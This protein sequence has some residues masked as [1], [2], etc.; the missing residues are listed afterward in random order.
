M[1][2]KQLIRSFSRKIRAAR[3]RLNLTQVEAAARAGCLSP[4]QLGFYEQG[5]KLPN[6][7]TLRKL[8]EAYGVSTDYLLGRSRRRWV[9]RR[10]EK[11]DHG[12][13]D[14]PIER[15]VPEPNVTTSRMDRWGRELENEQPTGSRELAISPD[16]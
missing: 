2:R 3:L 8:A 16:I 14:S 7:V 12:I 10:E 9:D 4:T 5:L 13:E 6:V 11:K 15:D 1:T